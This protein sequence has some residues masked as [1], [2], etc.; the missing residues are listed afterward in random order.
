MQ[1]LLSFVGGVMLS[2]ALLELLPLAIEQVHSIDQLATS[3]LIGLVA[4]FLI[5]RLFNVHQHGNIDETR[6]DHDHDH[7]VHNH[8]VSYSPEDCIVHQRKNSWIGLFLGLGFHSIIDGIAI[9]AIFTVNE[10]TGTFWNFTLLAPLA[11]MVL[12]LPFE[13]FSLFSV[14]KATGWSNRAIYI[15]NI[16]FGTAAP[17]GTVLFLAGTSHL[18]AGTPVIGIGLGIAVGVC[19]C[20]SLSDILPELRF[21]SRDRLPLI[22]ALLLGIVSIFILHTVVPHAHPTEI[23]P[24]HPVEQSSHT[25]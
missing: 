24:N 7:P 25:R 2:V 12:H 16:A 19:L 23:H 14:M 21:D 10:Q 4:T 6:I 13:S 22:A 18:A 20:V 5:T 11:V 3:I 17:L 9:G 15:T 8:V 1:V